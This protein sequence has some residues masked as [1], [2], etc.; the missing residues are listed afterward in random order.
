MDITLEK[1]NPTE[2]SI[3]IKLTE[4]DYQPKVTEK[5]KDYGKKAQIKGFRPGKVPPALINKMYGKSIMIEEI[6]HMLSH[7][8]QDYIK[9]NNLKIL[10]EP[11]PNTEDADQIDWDT[12]KDFDF[13][14]EIGLVDEFKY[15]LDDKKVTRY[16]IKVDDDTIA[17]T[18][19]NL[20][21]QYGKMTN[22]EKSEKGDFLYGELKAVEGDFD[23]KLS[24]PIDRVSEK[25]A[26]KFVGV[27]KGDKVKFDINE[28]FKDPETIAGVLNIDIEK[29]KELN[30]EFE[31]DV[32]NVNRQEAAVLDQ[33]FFDKIFGKDSVK[34]EDEFKNKVKE[35][36]SQNYSRE[37]DAYLNNSI[38]EAIIKDTEVELPND[39]LKKWLLASNEGKITEEDI[40]NE[41][42]A[43]SKDIKWTLIQ[44]KIIEDQEIKVE[45]QDIEL[46]AKELIK[47]QLASS[48]LLGQFDD[49]LDVFV[50]NYLQSEKGE[51][52]MKIFNQVKAEK[53]FNAIKEK[54]TI[55][56]KKVDVEEFK[57]IVTN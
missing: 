47:E 4:A 46:K 13:V 40:K 12:Q 10:G 14:F 38:Q 16:E 18:L 19:D 43:Y 30:G 49:N 52:Y 3:K 1:K 55:E 5:L 24:I 48:G 27:S 28:A 11:L 36:I 21:K 17:E 45:N 25:L 39:F 15:N 35:T 8:V 44:N 51:N 41:Y 2:A 42:D 34:S 9:D 20:Q 31:L 56:D 26:D 22:P 29:A 37:T 33:D 50:Q 6:N 53:V 57:N 32:L 23:D 54:I 7:S